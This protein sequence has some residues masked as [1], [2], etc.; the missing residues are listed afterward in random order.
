[1]GKIP[2]EPFSKPCKSLNHPL[3]EESS[4]GFP[5]MCF[6]LPSME[7]TVMYQEELSVRN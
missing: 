7:I 4:I 3:C 5:L 6:K 2:A 1:M